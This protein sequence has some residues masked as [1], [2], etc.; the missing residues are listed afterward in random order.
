MGR[1]GQTLAGMDGDRNDRPPIRRTSV[2][3]PGGVEDLELLLRYGIQAATPVL[4]AETTAFLR[5][6]LANLDESALSGPDKI[7]LF[8]LR[9]EIDSGQPG[10]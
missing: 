5:D 2:A 6:A 1:S 7:A 3:A 4:D 10:D 8:R 9:R